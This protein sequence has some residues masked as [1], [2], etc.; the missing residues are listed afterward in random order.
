MV[1]VL[2]RNTP[3]A[4]AT[5]ATASYNLRPD[6]EGTETPCCQLPNP[7]RLWGYNLRPD[8]EGTETDKLLPVPLS[9]T[10]VTTY[11]PMVRVLKHVVGV[12]GGGAVGYVTTYDPMVRVLKRLSKVTYPPET[13]RLQPTTRW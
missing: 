10:V 4:Y 9:S 3:N 2:K 7:H 8:G 6:G 11:D 13:V 5:R 1:R 12:A